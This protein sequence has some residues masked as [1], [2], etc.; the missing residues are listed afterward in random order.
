MRLLSSVDF[1]LILLCRV[2]LFHWHHRY[3]LLVI[4]IEACFKTRILFII[5]LILQR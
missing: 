2:K 1:C 5:T 4:V 3:M